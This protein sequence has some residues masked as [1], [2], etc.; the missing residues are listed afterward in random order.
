VQEAGYATSKKWSMSRQCLQK[1]IP[2]GRYYPG[3]SLYMM[4]N[5]HLIFFVTCETFVTC[6][7]GAF[8]TCYVCDE[9]LEM[10]G[11]LLLCM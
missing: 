11:M 8:V 9:M 10:D 1:N 5:M 4:S 3:V 2:G 6:Y 7:V